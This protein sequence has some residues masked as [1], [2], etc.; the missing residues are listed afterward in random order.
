MRRKL[1]LLEVLCVIMLPLCAQGVSVK[2]SE[3]KQ[4]QSWVGAKFEGIPGQEEGEP[5]I[6]VI[7]NYDPVQM[8]N[9][10]GHPM[11]MGGKEYTH[12]LYCHA[13][14]HLEVIIPEGINKF[15]A[16][17][18]ID[19]NDQTSGGRGSVIGSIVSKSTTIWKTEVLREGMDPL[20]VNLSLKGET[21]LSLMLY[22][23][24]DGYACDQ[25]DWADAKVTLTNGKELWLGDLPLTK[26]SKKP[27]TEELPFSFVYEDHSSRDRLM[28]WTRERAM[29]KLDDN[30]SARTVTYTDPGTLLQVRCEAI[31]YHDYPVVEWTLYFKNTGTQDTP[32]IEN[33]RPLDT[34]FTR[35][36]E[37]EYQLRY[38]TG[39]LCTADSYEP[40]VETLA[41]KAQKS[42]ANTG[43]RPTQSAFPYFN[44][45]TNQEGMIIVVSWA[46]QW[47]S[48]FTRD[49][50]TGI[51]VSA[52]QELTHFI[53]H[54]GEEVRTPMIV[55]QFWQGDPLTAQNIWRRWMVDHSLPRPG[56]KLPPAPMMEA[57]SS[58]WFGEMINADSK[59]QMYFV[60][61]YLEK[62]MKLDYWW[63]DAGW[64]INS[65][66]WPN[67]GTWEVDEKRFPGGFRPITDY[68]RTKGVK[69]L[70]W[71][72]PER[73]TPGTWLYE[74]HPEWLLGKDGEWKLLNLGNTEAREW[75][76][77]HVDKILVDGG[78][79]FYRQDFNFDPLPYWRANDTEDRQGI[80]EIRHVEGYFAYWDGLRQRHPEMLIDSCASG[81]RRNDLET[82]RRAVPLLR[83]DY[84][85]EPVGNQ[86]HT[87]ALSYWF[88]YYGTGS[89]KTSTYDVLS[90]LCPSFNSCWDLRSEEIDWPRLANIIKEWKEFAPNFYG[91]Y[92]PL[93]SYSLGNDQWIAWQFNRPEAGEGMV[94]AFRRADSSFESARFRLSALEPEKT[95]K[96]WNT[97]GGT[98]VEQ[99]GKELMER[100]LLISMEE[101]PMAVVYRYQAV[102]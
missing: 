97:L 48:Q 70:V 76:T 11:K 37:N 42:I 84:I 99:S 35:G 2:D 91:D 59:S 90:V 53:L 1:I 79:D 67:T 68:I 56:G 38:H 64:Y 23:S 85:M 93:T 87:Y 29:V 15:E 73:V 54:P 77:N 10:N 25:F 69:S 82:L 63:M 47:S 44:L 43:G 86:C 16:I 94:Q 18:G 17:V 26:P 41:P 6:E 19:S 36:G 102:K 57:C 50:R 62:G 31:E 33:I 32:V 40:H 71:F 60:D 92:Y 20:P 27:F 55:V 45:G 88:P 95:Y 101:R 96:V 3:M 46:G 75:L 83:S 72:E 49:D 80:T 21:R 12:G 65:W 22:D 28:A 13:N 74:K 58:H 81:G 24:G 39:D 14:S 34:V 61:R 52:G 100:G 9:R 89:S 4:L 5:R 8:N 51:T 78:I 66:G 98:P 7:E 30:R